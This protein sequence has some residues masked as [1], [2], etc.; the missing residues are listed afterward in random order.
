MNEKRKIDNDAFIGEDIKRERALLT[1]L[2][3]AA[4]AGELPV[5]SCSSKS[6]N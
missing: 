4:S 1:F 3:D 6:T 2:G 5:T